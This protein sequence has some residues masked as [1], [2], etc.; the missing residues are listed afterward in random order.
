MNFH[1]R[2]LAAFF[3]MFLPTFATAD[4]SEASSDRQAIKQ[5]IQKMNQSITERNVD[6]L[7]ETFAEGAIDMEMFPAHKYGETQTDETFVT[8]TRPLSQRWQRI[9]PILFASTQRY[10]RQARI[11]DL[12]IDGRMA[13][14][15][16]EV[17]TESLSSKEGAQAKQDRFREIC[18][19]R[20][21]ESG[22]KIVTLSNNRHDKV[23]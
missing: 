14:A 10:V 1:Q 12:Q 20:H 16:L 23:E 2:L 6:K 15:W 3:L 4:E 13:S 18:I 22:W 19:L 17:E 9:A 11:L 7:L 8:K 5:V 21:Y